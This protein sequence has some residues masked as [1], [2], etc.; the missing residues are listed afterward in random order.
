MYKNK[1][2][3]DKVNENQWGLNQTIPRQPKT[4]HTVVDHGKALIIHPIPRVLKE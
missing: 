4:C 1:T 3:S 2:P